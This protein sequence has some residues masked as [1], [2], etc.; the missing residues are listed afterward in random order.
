MGRV[1]SCYRR[2]LRPTWAKKLPG[3][4]RKQDT[5]RDW[6]LPR[7]SGR[8]TGF[9]PASV[10]SNVTF[11]EPCQHQKALTKINRPSAQTLRVAGSPH[12]SIQ[13]GV[14]AVK[15]TSLIGTRTCCLPGRGLKSGGRH[16]LARV[17]HGLLVSLAPPGRERVAKN[18]IVGR[19]RYSD[20]PGIESAQE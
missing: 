1:L 12:P 2:E 20:T 19:Q 14:I 16:L 13:T 8:C 17:N 4:W 10:L 18:V 3:A 11:K 9:L 6:G 15:I 5:G 7:K